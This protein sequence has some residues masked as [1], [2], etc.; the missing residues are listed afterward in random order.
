MISSLLVLLV[1]IK[2]KLKCVTN[3]FNNRQSVWCK[4]NRC[5][6]HTHPYRRGLA[7]RQLTDVQEGEALLLHRHPH[8]GGVFAAGE[9]CFHGYLQITKN[10]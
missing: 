4:I 7:G 5:S 6:V 2:L 1:I 10:K 3:G 9:H 8:H